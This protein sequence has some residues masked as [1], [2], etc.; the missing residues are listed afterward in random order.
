M[1]RGALR[2]ATMYVASLLADKHTG[3]LQWV[4]GLRDAASGPA[5]EHITTD[6]TG[7]N[8]NCQKQVFSRVS[9]WGGTQPPGPYARALLILFL[10]SK[11]I[12][13]PFVQVD[14]KVFF[15]LIPCCA[16]AYWT[17]CQV[18]HFSTAIIIEFPKQNCSCNS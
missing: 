2:V 14:R 10:V 17:M 8:I 15:H 6:S 1:Q 18:H 4:H 16:C 9:V 5:H 11:L 7:T 13:I 3:S 12:T